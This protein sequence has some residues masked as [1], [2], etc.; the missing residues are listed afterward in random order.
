MSL[1]QCHN[2]QEQTRTAEEL[3]MF[4]EWNRLEM[5]PQLRKI[6]EQEKSEIYMNL[7][8]G[9]VFNN[10]ITSEAE[11]VQHNCEKS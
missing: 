5:S 9:T 1:E 11:K 8:R 6:L 10:S 3:L 2:G 4:K 7:Q